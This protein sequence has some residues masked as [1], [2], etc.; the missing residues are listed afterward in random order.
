MDMK[1]LA[2]R[3]MTAL[4]DPIG[5]CACL[6]TT[7]EGQ[8]ADEQSKSIKENNRRQGR[9]EGLI[10]GKMRGIIIIQSINQRQGTCEVDKRYY[11]I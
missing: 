10:D 3:N 9:Q 2:R 8:E 1:C 6:G 5:Q 4:V 11:L 7:R